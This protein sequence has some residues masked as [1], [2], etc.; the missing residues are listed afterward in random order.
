MKCW[1]QIF[2]LCIFWV[3]ILWLM[4]SYLDLTPESALQEKRMYL[5]TWHCNCPWFK[6]GMCGCPSGTLNCSSCYYTVRE[7]NWFDA[8]Y[9]KTMGYLMQTK[10]SMTSDIGLWW[11]GMNSASVFGKVWKMLFKVI[12]RPLVH[13]F[14][15]YCETCAVLG[16][17]LIPPGS[18]LSNNIDQH[19]MVFRWKYQQPGSWRWLVL[20]LLKLSD[21]SWTS[22]TLSGEME[23][24][25]ILGLQQQQE[26]D[27]EDFQG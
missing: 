11:L 18:G 25:V 1:W 20:L 10:E 27:C 26:E 16:N 2:V 12:P 14:D 7:W 13:H 22:D 3:L 17:S 5:G 19:P 9:E 4:T 15:F 6:F 8:C 21:L 23:C 24:R